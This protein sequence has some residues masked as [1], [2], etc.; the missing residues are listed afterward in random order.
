[1]HLAQVLIGREEAYHP[2]RDHVAQV[3][4]DAARLLHLQKADKELA[5]NRCHG[6]TQ[7]APLLQCGMPCLLLPDHAQLGILVTEC[8][9]DTS[10]R[11]HPRIELDFWYA[12]VLS[13]SSSAMRA[14]PR[15]N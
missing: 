12:T 6:H 13:L 14:L 15:T 7:A 1:M 11:W 4:E 2:S 9:Y 3:T 8:R 10:H 5:G